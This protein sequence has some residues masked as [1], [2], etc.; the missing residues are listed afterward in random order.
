MAH[1][2]AQIYQ[3]AYISNFIL[4][5]LVLLAS[6]VPF[7]FE[8]HVVLIVLL[9]LAAAVL[10]GLI[11][12]NTFVGNL[13]NWHRRWMEAREVAERLRA[14]LPIWLLGKRPRKQ[15]ERER[16]WVDWYVSAHYRAM[17]ICPGTLNFQRLSA[18]KAILTGILDDQ[19]KYHI[20][21]AALMNR[22]ERRAFYN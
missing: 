13:R 9:G 14:G 11:Y 16:T 8:W 5:A 7:I 6:V 10:L 15:S 20:Q 4:A 3:S 2:Y 21:S 1:R 12:I 18:I 19:A 17:G 22:I